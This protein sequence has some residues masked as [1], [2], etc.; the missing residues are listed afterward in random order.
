MKLTFQMSKTPQ[1]TNEHVAVSKVTVIRLGKE[2][3]VLQCCNVVLYFCV[4]IV[5]FEAPDPQHPLPL[6]SPCLLT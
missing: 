5:K 1:R 3:G 2:V 4:E 6:I